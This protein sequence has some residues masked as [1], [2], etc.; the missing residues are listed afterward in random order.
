MNSEEEVTGGY[1]NFTS[2]WFPGGMQPSIVLVHQELNLCD[3]VSKVQMKCP[4]H[5]GH[6]KIVYKRSALSLILPPVSI[7]QYYVPY[8]GSV[9]G[10]LLLPHHRERS[11]E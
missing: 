9:T 8:Y 11:V 10:H 4:I 5:T 1:I 3:F 7:I 6:H 2:H